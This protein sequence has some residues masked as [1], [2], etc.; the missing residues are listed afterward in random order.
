MN[1][2]MIV[3]TYK[4]FCL[5]KLDCRA[6][7]RTDTC[8]RKKGHEGWHIGSRYRWHPRLSEVRGKK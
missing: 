6:T 3:T 1:V 7:G 4:P 8:G 2:R 5:S